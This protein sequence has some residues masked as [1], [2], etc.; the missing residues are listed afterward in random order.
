[1]HD[2]GFPACF[3]DHTVSDGQ[4]DPGKT[5]VLV[6]PVDTLYRHK[7]GLTVTRNYSLPNLVDRECLHPAI[8]RRLD[9]MC[10]VLE[11]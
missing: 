11:V 3:G 6:G 10:T 8:V 7:H 9:D 4:Y 2:A 5:D 1:M